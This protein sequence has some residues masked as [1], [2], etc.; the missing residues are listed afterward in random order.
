[1]TKSIYLAGGCFWGIEKYLSLI[2]G[3]VFTEAGYANGKTEN[4]TYEQI[5][6]NNTGYAE[7]VKVIYDSEKLTLRLLLKRF[8]DV[9]DPTSF[10]KQGNDIGEQYRTGIYYTC[11]KDKNDIFAALD[12]L[13]AH[14]DSPIVIEAIPL[15]KYYP[16]EEYHQNYLNK[17]PH[18]YCHIPTSAFEQAKRTISSDTNDELKHSLSDIQYRVTRENGTEPPFNNEYYNEYRDGIYVD[19]ISGEPLFV[20]TDKFESGCG[21]PS[22]SKPIDQHVVKELPDTSMDMH[23]TEVRSLGSNSHLGHVFDDGPADRGGLRYCINSASLRFI[24]KEQM[25]EDGYEDYLILI[26]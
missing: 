5:C 16:A 25:K 8:F 2:L 18:G 15:E 3:V 22:F 14:Y 4:P 20:S 9:I 21:W 19:I 10:N 24:P 12:E 6:R 13:Q 17:N 7:T 1:M 11:L 23:R 26:E